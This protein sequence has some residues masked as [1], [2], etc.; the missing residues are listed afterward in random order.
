MSWHLS[1]RLVDVVKA[2]KIDVL[3]VHYAI[4]HAYAGLYGKKNAC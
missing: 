1:S 4:P 3:H 2:N